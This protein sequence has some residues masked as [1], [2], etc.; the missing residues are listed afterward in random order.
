M[1]GKMNILVGTPKNMSDLINS[2]ADVID[3][4]EDILTANQAT[5]FLREMADYFIRN[6]ENNGK[7]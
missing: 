5:R 1:D 2:F 4:D 3:E 7:I 6:G